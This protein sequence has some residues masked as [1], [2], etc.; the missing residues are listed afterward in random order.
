MKKVLAFLLAIVMTLGFCALTAFAA[1]EDEPNDK[2]SQATSIAL[3]TEVTAKLGKSSDE[4]WFKIKVPANG[5]IRV[6]LGHELISSTSTYWEI[7]VYQ[8][9]GTTGINDYDGYWPVHGNKDGATCELGVSAGTYYIRIRRGSYHDSVSYTLKVHYEQSDNWEQEPNATMKK[10]TAIQP[11]QDYMGASAGNRDDDWYQVIIPAE[12]YMQVHFNHEIISSASSHW[13]FRIYQADGVTGIHEYDGY[14]PVPGNENRSSCVIGVPAGTYYIRISDGSYT[15]D[16]PYTLRV[17]FEQ[18]QYAESEPNTDSQNATDI[19]VNQDYTGATAGN[20]DDDWYRFTV[21]EAGTISVDF[22]HEIISSTSSH[23]E[24][25]IYQADAVTGIIGKDV[26]WSVTGNENRSSCVIGVP[27]G[28]YYVRISD[29]S[30]TSDVPYTLRVNFEANDFAEKEVNGSPAQATQ[31]TTNKGYIGSMC[32]NADDDWYVFNLSVSA[33]VTLNFTHEMVESASRHWDVYLYGADGVTKIVDAGVP[34]NENLSL[35]TGQ[36]AAGTYYIK[37]TDSNYLSGNTYTINV[38]EKHD[39]TGS[40]K[41]T[42]EPTCIESGTREQIC[43]ICDKTM[44]TEV[45]PALGHNVN[46]W[47]VIKESTCSETGYREGECGRCGEFV[48]EVTGVL[49]HT[50][51][52]WKEV[53]GNKLIPPI[54]SSQSC[55]VCGYENIQK[56]WSNIWITIL[57]GLAAI[58]LVV[59]VVNYIRT[60]KSR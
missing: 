53:S 41:T 20:R 42:K 24:F 16:V 4:D 59:G 27:A 39:C 34:G 2:K 47:N 38:S 23:W 60:F 9:D 52:E 7:R 3:N 14:W 21:S 57:A 46:N 48:N 15:S 18:T 19:Q 40:W 31:I 50:Y 51:G 12:G 49:P 30:Y 6:E 37:I 26:Y 10:A 29:G 58:G 8:S 28:T 33:E 13:E 22:R 55:Q 56:D 43:H 54:V 17:T 44:T 25:R 11:N 36:L 5:H 45:I 32:S 35:A 1:S